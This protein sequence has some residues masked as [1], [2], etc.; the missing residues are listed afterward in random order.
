MLSKTS[1]KY[2]EQRE[3]LNHASSTGNFTSDGPSVPEG[4]PQKMWKLSKNMAN[5]SSNLEVNLS[6]LLP[7]FPSKVSISDKQP[8]DLLVNLIA[9]N[10]ALQSTCLTLCHVE[11]A[12][13]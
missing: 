6:W 12:I 13:D 8:P 1:S 10:N 3:W 4:V 9:T 2:K 5:D 11:Q 7:S